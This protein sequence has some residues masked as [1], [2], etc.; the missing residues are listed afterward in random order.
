MVKAIHD[1]DDMMHALASYMSDGP[2][3][4][5][6]QRRLQSRSRFNVATK[7]LDFGLGSFFTLRKVSD[8][9]DFIAVVSISKANTAKLQISYRTK[10]YANQWKFDLLKV[11]EDHAVLDVSDFIKSLHRLHPPVPDIFAES[12]HDHVLTTFRELP[13]LKQIHDTRTTAST[14][15]VQKKTAS[16]ATTSI[17]M[18]Y[19]SGETSG[20][21]VIVFDVYSSKR[22]DRYAVC[23]RTHPQF[24]INNIMLLY[25][26]GLFAKIMRLLGQERRHLDQGLDTHLLSMTKMDRNREQVVCVR[27]PE[28]D[29][30]MASD[31]SVGHVYDL[32]A[33]DKNVANDEYVTIA[34]NNEDREYKSVF[35]AKVP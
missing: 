11:K 5:Q 15:S 19:K 26:R 8:T 23:V 24:L 10:A 33:V 7:S 16:A 18:R 22:D 6:E 27:V 21:C 12:V 31:I 4:G 28:A 25:N 34:V 9:E 13:G 17:S 20:K 2:D 35:F 29:G 1:L 14:T 3:A 32:K 30:V